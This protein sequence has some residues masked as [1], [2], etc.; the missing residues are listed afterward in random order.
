FTLFVRARFLVN[1]FTDQK[2]KHWYYEPMYG[3]FYPIGYQQRCTC[4]LM[5]SPSQ[6]SFVKT[7]VLNTRLT[8]STASKAAYKL[9]LASNSQDVYC[10]ETFPLR[11]V[12]FHLAMS[13]R[14]PNIAS[15]HD[16][17]L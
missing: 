10:P 15:P 2:K 8:R 17:F 7:H 5:N 4:A 9:I 14:P 3:A 6:F 16:T 13:L 12:K 11:L 1:P